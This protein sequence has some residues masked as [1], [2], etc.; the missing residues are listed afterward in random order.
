MKQT[1][2]AALAVALLSSTAAVAA[3][4]FPKKER[5]EMKFADAEPVVV[6]SGFYLQGQGGYGKSQHN[7][8]VQS[9][10]SS[11]TSD[12]GFVDILGLDGIGGDGF[13]GGGRLGY[14]LAMGRFLVGVFGEYNWSNI[15]T[16]LSLSGFP[17]SPTYTLEKENEWSVGARAGVIVAPRTLAYIL[18]AYTE[19][20]YTINGPGVVAG[21]GY[22]TEQTLQGF[23]VGAGAEYALAGNVFLGL[24]GTYTFYDEAEWA[25]SCSSTSCGRGDGRI[26]AETDE[27]KVM[28]TLKIKLNG[29]PF[30]K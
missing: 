17:G 8:T 11:G 18:A 16:E 27:L 26:E 3:D 7:L 9:Y 5:E 2:I 6:W 12:V 4:P 21:R 20:D 1:V 28:G 15:E 30:G 29:D 22:A 14:D 23:T 10:D 24:E 25:N 13:I 19:T